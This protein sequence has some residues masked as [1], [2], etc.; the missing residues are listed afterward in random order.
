MPNINIGRLRGGLCV[1]WDDP[2]TGKRK[3]YQLTSRSRKDAEA[4]AIEV[5]RRETYKSSPRGATIQQ[6]WDAYVADLGDKPTAKTMSFTGKAILPHFGAFL[7]EDIDKPL[8][9][10]YQRD[11]R[12]AG[13]K[14]GTIWTELGHLQSA[15][16]FGKKARM[17]EGATPHIWR[18]TKPES[19]KRILSAKEIRA[20]I[21]AAHDP[22]IRL[23]LILL[24]G[25]AARVGA[26]LDLTWDRIDLDRGVIN[27]RKDDSA[28][29]KG[30][31]VVPMNASARAALQTASDAAL[32]DYVIEYA[33]GPVK[34][35]RKG[36]SNAIERAGIG[37]VTIH[38]LRHTAAVHLLGAGIP[39]EKVSQYLGHSNVQITFKTYARFL[40]DQMQDAAEVLDFMNFR[41]AN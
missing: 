30:R 14:Q 32:S 37:H 22:H 20:L 26:I 24:L 6:I 8:C 35:I 1:Y 3:R 9:Q 23:A 19:D 5:F 27:L 31:A 13:K 12:E 33:G 7:P 40:P 34:S 10:A 4:E 11:R 36:V 16:N 41:K 29:R 21:S 17:I 25:T 38:E 2:E 15:L 39:I 18:P 28:T